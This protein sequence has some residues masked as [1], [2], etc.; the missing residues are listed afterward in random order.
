MKTSGE[1]EQSLSLF[2]FYQRG[3]AGDFGG[4]HA[5]AEAAVDAFALFAVFAAQLDEGLG[6]EGIGGFDACVGEKAR[7]GVVFGF[8]GLEKLD[9]GGECV[10]VAAIC[11]VGVAQRYGGVDYQSVDGGAAKRT[12]RC[13]LRWGECIVCSPET[14]QG[15]VEKLTHVV[16]GVGFHKAT[17]QVEAFVDFL[18]QGG[19]AAVG[20]ILRAG[21]RHLP[22]EC[23]RPQ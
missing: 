10:V 4:E 18:C 5:V 14:A 8:D 16:D 17:H 20:E 12:G 22:R 11:G 7:N 2:S 19:Y 6:V 21:A 1:G 15:Y 9:V 13:G 3:L 23:E